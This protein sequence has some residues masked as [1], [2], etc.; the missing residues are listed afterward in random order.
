MRTLITVIGIFAGGLSALGSDWPTDGG[1][2]QR[3]NWQKDET[4]LAKENVSS[5]KIL[6]KLK[7]DNTPRQMHSLFPP[8]IIGQV[9]TASGPKQIALEAGVSDN[10]YA[11]DVDK[12]EILWNRHFEYPPP[13]RSGGATDP[14][15]PGGMTA[16]PVIGPPTAAGARTVYALAGNGELHSINLITGEDITPPVPFGYPNGKAY[17]LNLWNNVIF[18]T[19]SQGC[20]GNP[21]QVWAININD[22]PARRSI[23]TASPGSRR[24]TALTTWPRSDMA[25]G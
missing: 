12:G 14:L 8:L 17:A 24:E 16:T 3:T 23:R 25:T 20:A 19:T 15:C 9:N 18:T 13:A 10:L 22:E 4:I 11:I 1:N 6:W 21:N 7:L 2:P 5:L